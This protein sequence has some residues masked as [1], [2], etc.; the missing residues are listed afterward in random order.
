MATT[1]TTGTCGACFRS[2]SLN[3][4][5]TVVRHGWR[6]AGG[7][8]RAGA[9]GNVIHSGAC[10][11]VGWLPF[12]T[13]PDC[14]TAFVERRLFPMGLEIKRALRHLATRPPL[15]F[16]GSTFERNEYRGSA[17]DIKAWDGY[18]KWEA[19]L[20]NG[21]EASTNL[22]FYVFDGVPT[23]YP[24]TSSKIPS[25]GAERVRRVDAL[26]DEWKAVAKDA[27]YCC[28]KVSAWKP[29]KTKTAAKAVKL[30]HAA[31]TRATYI[32]A[33]RWS[34]GMS[35]FHIAS[36]EEKVTCSK[37]LKALAERAEREAAKASASA[38]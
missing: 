13:S 7:R 31:G 36:G 21:D 2:M 5:G 25:Y 34:R 16:S 1:T 18:A 10:F 11:G 14:T 22:C 32:P 19:R 35:R 17:P 30:V 27:L 23:F 12:E 26:G 33:C 9:Y 29:T 6:E 20:V 15:I 37:C 38:G 8:R 24:N 28:A 4:D 3:A